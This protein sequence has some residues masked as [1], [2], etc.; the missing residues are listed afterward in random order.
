MNFDEALGRVQEHLAE[1]TQEHEF[2]WV[3]FYN[4]TAYIASSDLEDALFG[5]APIIVN[6]KTGELIPTGTA[7]NTAY[8]VSNYAATNDPHREC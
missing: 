3:F 7:R 5:N 6:R 8:Y 2:G 1:L 4:T